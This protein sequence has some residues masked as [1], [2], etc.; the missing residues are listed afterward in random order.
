MIIKYYI[1]AWSGHRTRKITLRHPAQYIGELGS[2]IRSSYSYWAVLDM[3]KPYI[4][5]KFGMDDVD[6][7]LRDSS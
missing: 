2:V 1:S 7:Y 4:D 3:I 6:I 5:F